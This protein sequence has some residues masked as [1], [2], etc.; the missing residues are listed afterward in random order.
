MTP[1]KRRRYVPVDVNVAFGRFGTRLD[2]KWGMEGLCAWMLLLAAAKREHQQ[3]VFTYTS[4]TEAWGKLGATA[5][6][7]GFDEFIT[8]CGRNKQTRKTASG[9]V[10]YVEITGWTRWN[11]EFRQQ[12]NSEQKSRKRADSTPDTMRTDRGHYADT[13]RTEVE[14]DSE[15]ENDS[16]VAATIE[17]GLEQRLP[18]SLE[19]RLELEKMLPHLHDRDAGS[20]AVLETNARHLTLAAICRVRDTI[21]HSPK[22]VGVGYAVNALKSEAKEAA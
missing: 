15:Y 5:T 17:A 13:M 22:R 2:Q 8:Y 16:E 18:I 3:G 1:P 10:N 7:F 12:A 9:R 6:K 21:Q 20:L 14:A 11:N 4:E 19:K